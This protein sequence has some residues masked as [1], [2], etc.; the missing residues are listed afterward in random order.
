M[1]FAESYLAERPGP[2]IA[3]LFEGFLD[4]A[5]NGGSLPSCFLASGR[6]DLTDAAEMLAGDSTPS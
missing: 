3:L 5:D 6:V 2:T 4:P 1:V